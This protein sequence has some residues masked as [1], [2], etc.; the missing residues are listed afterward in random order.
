MTDS[1]AEKDYGNIFGGQSSPIT[2]KPDSTTKIY[3][4]Q[5]FYL[6]ATVKLTGH[7][8]IPSNATISFQESANGHSRGIKV[9]DDKDDWTQVPIVT[10][11]PQN[12][13]AT[14]CVCFDPDSADQPNTIKVN[15]GAGTWSGTKPAP[16]TTV[17]YSVATADPSSITCTGASQM[18][19]PI[20]S[21]ADGDKLDPSSAQYTTK[22][23]FTVK[24]GT[25]PV[26]GY[27][28]EWHEGGVENGHPLFQTYVNTYVSKTA[29]YSDRLQKGS[30]L[31]VKDPSSKD[32]FVRMVTDTRGKAE[33][34]LVAKHSQG[35][36]MSSVHAVYNF[37]EDSEQARPFLVTDPDVALLPEYECKVE[38]LEEVDNHAVLNYDDLSDPPTVRVEIPQ[39]QN[40]KPEDQFFLVLNGK[41]VAG[42]YDF[43]MK[44][45][46][47]NTSF[48]ENLGYSNIPPNA[49]KMNK[50]AFIVANK[51]NATAKPSMTREFTGTGNNQGGVI[52]TSGS[53][54][55]PELFPYAGNINAHTLTA[56]SVTI[57]VDLK[58]PKVDWNAKLGDK[59][60]AEAVLTGYKHRSTVLR[61]P[62]QV[63]ANPKTIGSA[64]KTA[65]VVQL[66]FPAGPFNNWDQ[67]DQPPWTEGKCYITYTVTR[68][69]QQIWKSQ[70]LS[71]TLNTADDS[72]VEKSKESASSANAS[73]KPA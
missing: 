44:W 64:E 31:L 27:V 19:L 2:I 66:Q 6:T 38:A 57:E 63:A 22:F 55:A 11:D 34:Y 52:P 4:N 37:S 71:V 73:M 41:I 21:S 10:T 29:T 48:L 67:M 58:Q 32:D 15:A 30:P 65:G 5:G 46:G 53:L 45:L 12:G 50:L 47:W 3:P 69:N 23:T 70:L 14:L 8:T 56:G 28:I 72:Y 25:T 61:Q 42:P 16:A 9:I 1:S 43:P 17:S 49:G 18:L 40:A 60:Q 26:P 51:F 54:Y 24:D 62:V 68:G 39:V 36:I 33:L 7:D 59:F 13:T 20:P 35:N